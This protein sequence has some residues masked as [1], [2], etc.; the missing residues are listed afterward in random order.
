[1]GKIGVSQRSSRRFGCVFHPAIT[2]RLAVKSSLH[3]RDNPSAA[4]ETAALNLEVKMKKIY[5]YIFNVLWALITILLITVITLANAEDRQ[6]NERYNYG[7]PAIIA[8]DGRFLGNYNANP[9]DPNSI[10]NPY[11]RYGSPYAPNGINNP[12]SRYGSPY[13]PYSVTNPYIRNNRW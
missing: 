12:Y 4:C 2:G 5:I 1:M 9:Y 13:S 8:P 6:Y 3:N 11:G 7:S 10:A